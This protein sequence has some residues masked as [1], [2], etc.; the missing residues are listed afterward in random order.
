M[1]EYIVKQ[2][3]TTSKDVTILG[4]NLIDAINH[5]MDACRTSNMRG[6]DG[7]YTPVKFFATER[8]ARWKDSILGGNGGVELILRNDN[9]T[10]TVWIKTTRAEWDAI[11]NG[12]AIITL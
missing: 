1:N 7:R 6:T 10:M 4:D 3:G 5:N 8:R 9:E 11:A 12:Q 2:N